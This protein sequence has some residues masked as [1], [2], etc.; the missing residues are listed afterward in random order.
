[1]TIIIA[2]DALTTNNEA[3][4]SIVEETCDLVSGYKLG[5]PNIIGNNPIKP[6]EIIRNRC[7]NTLIVTD[8][9]LADIYYIMLKILE[10]FKWSM[11]AVIAHAF[12]GT[13]G[14]LE[15][16]KY[17]LEQHNIKLILVA[18]MSHY[19]AS[20]VMDNCITYITYVINQ[21]NP[22][23]IVAPATRPKMINLFRKKLGKQVKILSPGVGAQGAT[24]GSA[25]KAGADYE[26]IG[27]MITLS[28]NPRKTVMQILQEHR[29]IY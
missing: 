18:T 1:M 9:K 12:I 29:K 26:I 4:R 28:D 17:A 15:E 11:D 6:I 14:A 10:S 5:W 19:G 7:P 3:I 20:E 21:I 13:T 24:P 2:L 22:W 23:G 25:L 27:R 8:L 16:L